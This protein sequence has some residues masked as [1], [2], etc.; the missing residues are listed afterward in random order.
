MFGMSFR[1]FLEL[2]YEYS[3]DSIELEDILENHL[4]ISLSIK[5]D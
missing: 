2:H 4:D 3:F 1:E 5:K